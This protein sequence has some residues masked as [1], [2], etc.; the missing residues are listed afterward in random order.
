MA[1]KRKTL[2]QKK[3]AQTRLKIQIEKGDQNTNT[4]FSYKTIKRAQGSKVIKKEKT[5]EFKESDLLVVD[6]KHIKTDLMRTFGMSVLFIA[7]LLGL[8]FYLGG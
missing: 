5:K 2:K 1:K 7:V 4:Q 3:A 6:F 8:Y